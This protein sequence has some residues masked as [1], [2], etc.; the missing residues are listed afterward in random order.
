MSHSDSPILDSNTLEQLLTLDDGNLGLFL[1]MLELFKEDTPSRIEVLSPLL[2]AANAQELADV[3]HA[4]KGAAS[5]MG[6]VRL[7]AAAAAIEASARTEN[8]NGSTASMVQRLKDEYALAIEAM[9]AFRKSR[10]A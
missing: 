4:I 8:L 5:T 6:A 2:D 1:E 7:R 9:E 10:E 3:A